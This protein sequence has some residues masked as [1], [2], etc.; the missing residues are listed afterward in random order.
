[1]EGA[2]VA[3]VGE[4]RAAVK[5]RIGALRW[6][7]LIAPVELAAPVPA[8]GRTDWEK[9]L[10]ASPTNRLNG[11]II[12][13]ASGTDTPRCGA[14]QKITLGTEWRGEALICTVVLARAEMAATLPAVDDLFAKRDRERL[15][16]ECGPMFEIQP[17]TA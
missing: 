16:A 6:R 3:R 9:L 8:K 12:K 14:I 1:M 11:L 4:R 13:I 5:T 2:A 7:S 10:S 17:A 15:P